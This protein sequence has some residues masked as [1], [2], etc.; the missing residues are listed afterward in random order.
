MESTILGSARVERSPSWSASPAEILRCGVERAGKVRD[1]AK[2]AG[3]R[4][5]RKGGRKR[6]ENEGTTSVD[7]LQ[8]RDNRVTHKYST[9]D[10]PRTCLRQ[11]SDQDDL[12]RKRE[13]R[14]AKRRRKRW[15][16]AKKSGQRCSL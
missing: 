5:G 12:R 9:H 7:G 3:R 1:V 4:T 14:R 13:G 11:I 8:R 16:T 6:G 10:L 2:G 15:R